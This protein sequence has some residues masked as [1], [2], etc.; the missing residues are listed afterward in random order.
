MPRTGEPAVGEE[1]RGAIMAAAK[2]V[3]ARNGFDGATFADVAGEAGLPFEAVYQ[4]FDSKDAL[5]GALI[6]AQE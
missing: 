4:Y 2:K 1:I 3:F 5:F 6:A